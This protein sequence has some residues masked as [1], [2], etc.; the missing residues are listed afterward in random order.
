M[1]ETKALQTTSNQAPAV[2]TDQGYECARQQAKDLA[3][4]DLVPTAYKGKPANCLIALETAH[5]T[6]ASVMAV[7]QNLNVIHGKTSW[8]SQWV[9]ATINSCGRFTPLEFKMTGEGMDRTC[10]AYATDKKSGAVTEGPSVSMQTAK[11]EGWY[12]KPGSKWK[13][14]PELMLR[15]RAGTF[16]GRLYVP[17]LLLGMQTDDEA[18]D[19]TPAPEPSAVASLNDK[20]KARKVEAEIV[21]EPETAP[22]ITYAGEDD[23]GFF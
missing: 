14:M 6:G 11:L 16:F 12:D 3:A 2:F 18:R 8:S 22:D 9:I 21:P 23:E 19:V 7:M 20:I 13:T 15:Y 10:V 4:S 1:T 5:R 17:D